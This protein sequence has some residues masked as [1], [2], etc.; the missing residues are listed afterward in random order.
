MR[1]TPQ[2]KEETRL[3]IVAAARELFGERGFEGTSTRDLA[4][5]AGIA[6]GTLFNYFSSK[7]SLAM[8]LA[9]E[10]L[11]R[12]TTGFLERRRGQESL[13]EDLFAHVASGLRE[14]A[15]Y[16]HFIGEVFETA[17]S[18]FGRS[19]VAEQG[20][21]VRLAHLETVSELLREHGLEE[22]Q[23]HVSIHLYWTLYLGVLGHWSK[24]ESPNQEDTL[25]VLDRSLRLYVASVNGGLDEEVESD[26]FQGR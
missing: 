19:A 13:E 8:T 16:R 21:Q 9:V 15:P 23:S 7:E 18:P 24:D 20:E 26:G 22:G 1:I 17:M 6:A 5:A 11:E 14:L 25:V 3:R 4:R 10:A 2:A 12:G